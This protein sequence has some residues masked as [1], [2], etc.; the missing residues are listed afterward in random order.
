MLLVFRRNIISPTYHDE[1]S[2]AFLRCLHSAVPFLPQNSR[3]LGS[4]FWFTVSIL[5]AEETQLYTDA[6]QVL[7][8][9]VE[10]MAKHGLFNHDTSGPQNPMATVLM[11]L[12]RPL[13]DAAVKLD[14]L[15]GLSFETDF[16]FAL[17]SIL[18]GGVRVPAHLKLVASVS[19]SLL[20]IS[21]RAANPKAEPR[22][23]LDATSMPLYLGLCAHMNKEEYIRLL[24]EDCHITNSSI[25]QSAAEGDDEAATGSWMDL[26]PF[27]LSDIR[28]VVLSIM[29]VLCLEDSNLVEQPEKETIHLIWSAFVRCYPNLSLS[30]VLHVVQYFT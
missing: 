24:E 1:V 4:I 6:V 14:Q 8:V 11:D 30:G 21:I 25:D 9:T 28:T 3:Y 7:L 2:I 22:R 27:G 29:F 23:C 13:W 5:Q 18:W 15:S 26:E 10:T 19:T 20:K 17:T 16:G 12:R